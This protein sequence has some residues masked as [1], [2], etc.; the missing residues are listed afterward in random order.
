M[1]GTPTASLEISSA[2]QSLIGSP[3]GVHGESARVLPAGEIHRTGSGDPPAI[4]PRS[5]H[6]P[7]TGRLP[8][9]SRGM[10]PTSHRNP[11]YL[12]PLS[13]L[14]MGGGPD[15]QPASGLAMRSI[16]DLQL[17]RRRSRAAAGTPM[18]TYRNPTRTRGLDPHGTC[19]TYTK[20][21]YTF[22][23]FS[24]SIERRCTTTHGSTRAAGSPSIPRDVRRR[25]DLGAGRTEPGNSHAAGPPTEPTNGSFTRAPHGRP[26]RRRQ[27][28]GSARAGRARLYGSGQASRRARTAG[29]GPHAAPER[30]ASG[31]AAARDRGARG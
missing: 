27:E 24:T 9:T 11:E 30:K 1:E 18:P 22:R 19:P 14:C 13:P 29:A 4:L 17:E 28:A 23:G 31:R 5:S 6:E 2:C 26:A 21:P 10:W 25:G 3:P 15:R 8:P 20:S 12:G 16:T 7:P